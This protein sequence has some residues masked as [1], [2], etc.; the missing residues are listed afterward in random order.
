MGHSISLRRNLARSITWRP[1]RR[2]A[3]SASGIPASS[4]LSNQQ[5]NTNVLEWWHRRQPQAKLVTIGTSCSY[6]PDLPMTEANYLQGDPIDSLF[7]Y[8]HTKRM[9]LVGQLALARQY[10]L[11]WVTLVPSTL[12][13]PDYHTDG[14][15]M[16]FI[17]DLI[18]KI[19]GAANGDEVPTLWGDGYQKRELIYVSD[20]VACAVQLASRCDNELVNVGAGEEFTIRQ[21]AEMICSEVGYEPGKVKYDVSRYTGAKSKRLSIEKLD[22][23]IPERPRTPLATGLRRT[24]EWFKSTHEGTRG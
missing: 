7:A 4:G 5:I 1:G 24:I 16:H 3:I 11:K 15:Q 13:G 10:G 8:A 19:I 17:F 12:Y 20:F 9:L 22:Q 2:R 21:F 18:R 14:R 6:S 23:L